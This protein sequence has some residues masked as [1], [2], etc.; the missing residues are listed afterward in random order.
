MFPVFSPSPHINIPL[1]LIMMSAAFTLSIV[2]FYKRAIQLNL[3]PKISTEISL[4]VMFGAFIGSRIFHVIFEY[5][6]YYLQSP[7]EI[8]KFFNGGFV[9]YGGFIGAI[10]ASYYYVKKLR[11][12][13]LNWLDCSAPAISLGYII[14]RFACF[15]AGCCYGKVC[16]LPWAIKF[17]EGVEAPAHTLLHPTQLYSI[18]I[19]GLILAT[20]LIL[21]KKCPSKFRSGTLFLV[22]MLLHSI[23]RLIVE[24]FRGDYRG[25]AL[26]GLSISSLISIILI[27]ISG[28]F[29]YI[30]L[31]PSSQK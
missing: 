23:G 1:Y 14:G 2:Y 31:K 20:L 3:P 30:N 9:F 28:G 8:L 10:L 12:N 25:E 6:Q 26:L 13:Y 5:P 27:L 11:Q 7:L 21:E 17:G 16:D 22:W 24:F 29:L 4:V 15:L 18:L 19:E